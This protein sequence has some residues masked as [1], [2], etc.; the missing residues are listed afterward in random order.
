MSEI[1]PVTGKKDGIR[2]TFGKSQVCLALADRLMATNSYKELG[3]I[4]SVMQDYMAGLSNLSSLP[5]G[6]PMLRYM[7]IVWRDHYLDIFKNLITV[8]QGQTYLLNLVK[9]RYKTYFNYGATKPN[10]ISNRALKRIK[11][12]NGSD[13]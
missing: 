2:Y 8:E 3:K 9:T 13:D 1:N 10:P 4:Q 7:S 5:K 12:Q 11:A 6:S